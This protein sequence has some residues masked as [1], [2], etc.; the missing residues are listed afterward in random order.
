MKKVIIL[1]VAFLLL[2][3]V[4]ITATRNVPQADF[5]ANQTMQSSEDSSHRQLNRTHWSGYAY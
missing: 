3:G 1:I 4:T 5:P 2:A